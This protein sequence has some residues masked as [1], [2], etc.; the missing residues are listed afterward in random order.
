MQRYDVSRFIKTN[1]YIYFA[2]EI[3]FNECEFAI[4]RARRKPQPMVPLNA[5]EFS[6]KLPGSEFATDHKFTISVG[7]EIAVVF[8]SESMASII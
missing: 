2:C 4:Y 6:E 5:A 8:Y 7:D 1:M 3:S